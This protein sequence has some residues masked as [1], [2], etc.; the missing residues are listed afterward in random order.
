MSLVGTYKNDDSGAVLNITSSNDANGEGKG[1]FKMGD[2]G[3][4]VVIHY[5]FIAGGLTGTTLVVSGYEDEPNHYTGSAGY[6]DTTT[7]KNGIRL[8]GGLAVQKNVIAFSG[9]FVKK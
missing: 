4:P 8:S 5:H 2:I 3:I 1:S 7:G 9:L 6:T